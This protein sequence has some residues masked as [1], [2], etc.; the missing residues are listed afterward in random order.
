M[1]NF[2]VI[3][4][5]NQTGIAST[6]IHCFNI[7]C[8]TSTSFQRY[9][10]HRTL[11]VIHGTNTK[12][13]SLYIDYYSNLYKGIRSFVLVPWVQRQCPCVNLHATIRL[14]FEC[15]DEVAGLVCS[16]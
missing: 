6:L 10:S 8:V 3:C 5:S 11:T 7:V 16:L 2:S 9:V 4:K 15:I 13:L 14:S 12:L 1:I